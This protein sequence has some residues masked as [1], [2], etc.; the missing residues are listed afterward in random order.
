[1][2]PYFTIISDFYHRAAIF[3]IGIVTVSARERPIRPGW[4][5]RDRPNVL[6]A[7]IRM[8]TMGSSGGGRAGVRNAKIICTLGPASDSVETI[9]RLVEAGMSVARLNASHG[10]TSDRAEII[11]RIR[12]VDAETDTP[13]ATMLDIAGPEVRT[14]PHEGTITLQAGDEVRFVQGDTRPPDVIGVSRSIAAVDPGDRVLVDDGRVETTV[15]GVG[16]DVVNAVVDSDGDLA[17]NKGVNVPEVD[18]GFPTVTDADRRELQLAASKAV[19]FVAASHVRS[20]EDVY[21]VSDILEHRSVEV[22][23]VAKIERADA[24]ANIE[25]IVEAAYGVMVARGDLGVE[26][27]LERVP[28]IQ[29]RIIR[30]CHEAGVPVITATEML[31]SMVH[32]SRPTRAEASDVANAVLDGTDA[33][34]LSGE[35]AVGDHPVEVVETMDRIVR[36]IEESDEY[37]DVREQIVPEADDTRTDALARSARYLARD[38]GA[39]AVVAA[40]ESGYTA[41][42]AA[43]YRPGVPIVASTPDHRVRR[44]LSLSWGVVPRHS[45]LPDEGVDD[46]ILSAVQTALNT[47]VAESGDTVVV[48]SGMMTRME[49]ADATNT[50]KVHVA[51]EALGTG[52]SVVAGTVTGPLY[53]VS[54]GDLSEVP[55]GTVVALP[56]EFDAEFR[57]DTTKIAGIVSADV[58]MTGYPA[59]VAREL[60]A[61]MVCG[62]TLPDAL[63]SG[64]V[65]SLDGDRGV[66]YRGDVTGSGGR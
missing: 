41:R 6:L 47:G 10:T 56:T 21:A 64:T 63:E 9:R 7:G 36:D 52:R 29:K 59:V 11:D 30:Q 46:L 49:G 13:V 33:V 20:A 25:G 43:K 51:A 4:Q 18:L 19:E 31:D 1:M 28:L 37:A 24:V 42:T 32:E 40:S 44:E 34:M 48:I 62:V 45:P 53:R 50:L 61:P 60:G 38:V 5:H 65:V 66:V 54:D 57:G 26:C 16:G 2:V 17:G 12:R 8:W 15:T 23:V 22:P 35:T 39:T 55:A 27:A 3:T 58:R 14:A